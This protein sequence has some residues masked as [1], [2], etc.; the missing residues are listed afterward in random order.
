MQDPTRE[1]R[2]MGILEGISFL[3]LLFIVGGIMAIPGRGVL[4]SSL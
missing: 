2:W 1:V 3:A 4:E